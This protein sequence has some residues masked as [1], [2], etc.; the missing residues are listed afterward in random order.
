[1]WM[2]TKGLLERLRQDREVSE[3]LAWPLDFELSLS[4]YD[5]GWYVVKPR[6]EAETIARDGTGGVF[7]LYG[8]D[9]YLIHITS[10]GQAGVIARDLAEGIALMVSYPYWRDLLKFS[11]GG[12]LNEMR[13][14]VP[15]LEREMHEDYPEIDEH[16]TLLR[17]KLSLGE[18]GDAIHLLHRA[19]A[20]LGQGIVVVA[21]DGTEFE[22]LFNTFTVDSIPTWRQGI[23][24][25]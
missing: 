10:E 21:P 17:E 13:R 8:S 12:Q 14:V 15:F 1:M 4:E 18:T 7:L 3:I 25:G 23:T 5:F 19:V 22:S 6:A 2:S 16:R 9:E 20:K 11:G 24:H